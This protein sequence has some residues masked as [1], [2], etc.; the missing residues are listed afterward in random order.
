MDGDGAGDAAEYVRCRERSCSALVSLS[1]M[2][3]VSGMGREA[4]VG[5]SAIAR[6]N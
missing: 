2:G 4:S 5:L 1:E 3:A 6:E